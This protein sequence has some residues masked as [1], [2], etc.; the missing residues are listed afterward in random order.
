MPLQLWRDYVFFPNFSSF[1]FINIHEIEPLGLVDWWGRCR[2]CVCRSLLFRLD[3][4]WDWVIIGVFGCHKVV[5]VVVLTC[6]LSPLLWRCYRDN[7]M[8]FTLVSHLS[9]TTLSAYKCA[10]LSRKS[11]YKMVTIDPAIESQNRH[12]WLTPLRVSLR[13]IMD[14]QLLEVFGP[15]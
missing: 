8:M 6:H 9:C 11:T 5:A 10:Q 14:W 2:W 15:P 3:C 7:E 13:S 1:S 12:S 4:V